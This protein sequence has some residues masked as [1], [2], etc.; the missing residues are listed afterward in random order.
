MCICALHIVC[1]Y[2]LTNISK[3][4]KVFKQ[5]FLYASLFSNPGMKWFDFEKNLPG[6]KGDGGVSEILAQW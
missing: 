1:V 5:S 3:S 2:L 4:I 6:E